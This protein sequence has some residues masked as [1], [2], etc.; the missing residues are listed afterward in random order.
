MIN[1]LINKRVDQHIKEYK[2]LYTKKDMEK[3][4]PI[5]YKQIE[6][7]LNKKLKEINFIK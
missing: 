7:K 1:E 4:R 3:L 6:D 2:G 5:W